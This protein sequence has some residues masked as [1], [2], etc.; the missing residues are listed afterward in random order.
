MEV[1]DKT[2]GKCESTMAV[3]ALHS[4]T[5]DVKRTTLTQLMLA[6]SDL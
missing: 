5:H 3:E 1:T 4:K 6:F 2:I